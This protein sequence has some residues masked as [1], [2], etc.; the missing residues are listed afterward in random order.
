[1]TDQGL[2]Y[3]FGRINPAVAWN[4]K[5][6]FVCRYLS[7][8][9]NS[10]CINAAEYAQLSAQGFE[11]ALN[12]EFQAKDCLG[13][14][15]SGKLHANEAVKQA[16]AVG[17]PAGSTIYFSADFDATEAQQ[18][19]INAY[20]AAARVILKAAG[21]RTGV[22]GGFYVVKRAFDAGVID[23]GWQ[24]YAWSG[25]QW[26]V[27]AAIHQD[28]NGISEAGCSCDHNTRVGVTYLGNRKSTL[29]TAP[30]PKPAPAP[31]PV[32]TYTVKAGDTLSGIAAKLGFKDWTVLYNANKAVIGPNPNV[33]RAGEVLTIPGTYVAP[34]PAP[35]PKPAPKPAPAPRTY[36]VKSGDSLSGIAAHYGLSWQALYNANKA[37]IGPNPNMIHVGLVLT[38]PA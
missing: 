8:L 20:L 12:W 37:H 5:Y 24:T 26:D 2:D 4:D 31:A 25:G 11:I 19:V 17:Y 15:A 35:A 16:R 21:Y 33:I 9:P 32:H 36:T 14:A 34:A 22:Y 30:P 3:S 1:M 27:R 13:G 18:P 7:W 23:D 28:R 38:I 29:P 6:R 10:K